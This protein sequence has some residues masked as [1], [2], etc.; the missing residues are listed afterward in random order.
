LSQV[1]DGHAYAYG[2]CSKVVLG[3]IYILNIDVTI[4][5]K[6]RGDARKAKRGMR[7]DIMI[8][9]WMSKLVQFMH[10]YEE[11]AMKSFCECVNFY[12]L[13]GRIEYYVFGGLVKPFANGLVA[14]VRIVWKVAPPFVCATGIAGG[15]RRFGGGGADR[16]CG[17]AMGTT[18][19]WL[20]C[21][22]SSG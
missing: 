1:S 7:M 16:R 22:T 13:K 17:A 9:L 11:H 8:H 10:L 12:S 18:D 3:K 20:G 6:G 21:N 2:S 14:E 5:T 4:M 19:A 15:F